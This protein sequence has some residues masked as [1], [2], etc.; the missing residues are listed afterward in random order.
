[1]S[2]KEKD[3]GTVNVAG[4]EVKILAIMGITTPDAREVT[5]MEI[6]GE[7]YILQVNNAEDSGRGSAHMALSKK[8]LLALL[9]VTCNLLDKRGIDH[10]AELQAVFGGPEVKGFATSNVQ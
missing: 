10:R 8:S 6:A 2:E 5:V 9:A 3:Y 7:R 4:E 1:M